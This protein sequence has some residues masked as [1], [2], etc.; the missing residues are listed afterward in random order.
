MKKGSGFAFVKALFAAAIWFGAL[1]FYGCTVVVLGAG[2]SV[3][4]WVAFTAM[5]LLISNLWSLYFKEWTDGRAKKV[6]LAGDAILVVAFVLVGIS[7][8]Y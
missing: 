5:A 1:F 4:G 3:T 6:L 8:Y 7:N 2:G